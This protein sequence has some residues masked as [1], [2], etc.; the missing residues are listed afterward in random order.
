[1]IEAL[2]VAADEALIRGE[3]P[4]IAHDG[5]P[6]VVARA[7]VQA[8]AYGVHHDRRARPYGGARVLAAG[9]SALDL[10]MAAERG[11]AVRGAPVFHGPWFRRRRWVKFGHLT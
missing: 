3:V 7:C 1:M 11:Q 2:L 6:M 10:D 4:T 9:P 8:D 5:S